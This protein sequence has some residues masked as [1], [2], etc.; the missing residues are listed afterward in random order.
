MK[1]TIFLSTLL[2]LILTITA[3]GGDAVASVNQIPLTPESGVAESSDEILNVPESTVMLNSDYENALPVQMQLILGTIWLEETDYSVDPN[4]AAELLPFWKAARS[5]SLS[6]TAAAEEIEA[7]FNQVAKTMTTE[8]LEAIVAMQ[9]SQNDLTVSADSLGIELDSGGKF[10]DMTPEEI[11][12]AQAARGGEQAPPGGGVP[13]ARPDGVVP[14]GN[15][16]GENRGA[17]GAASGINAMFYDAIIKA[18]EAKVQ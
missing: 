4:Q 17:G 12:A 11:A 15:P 1:K 6:D 18:L 8:Q 10:G 16:S 9:L 7:I 13:G 5:L 14:G 2:I 3:C